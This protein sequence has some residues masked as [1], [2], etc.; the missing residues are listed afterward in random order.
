MNNRVIPID[1]AKAAKLLMLHYLLSDLGRKK[2]DFL[3]GISSEGAF[4]N[5]LEESSKPVHSSY[6]VNCTSIDEASKCME[7]MKK[8]GNFGFYDVNN[9]KAN[10]R[11]K[12]NILRIKRDLRMMRYFPSECLWEPMF[13]VYHFFWRLRYN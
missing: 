2:E 13:R 3:C 12:K 6:Y 10:N 9:R 11:T 1:G 7:F 5:F 4:R 8:G